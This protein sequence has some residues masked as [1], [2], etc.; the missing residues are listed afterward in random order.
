MAGAPSQEMY[1]D[2]V[3]PL[4]VERPE[5][6]DQVSELVREAAARHAS[7]FPLGGGT[8]LDYGLPPVCTGYIC[9]LTG[10]NRLVEYPAA[11]MTVTVQAGRTLA[12]LQEILQERGQWLPIDVPLPQRT[13]LGG[14]LATNLP[15]PRRY[16]YGTW[17]DYVLGMVVVNDRGELTRSGGRVVKNVAG[18]DLHKLHIGALGTLGVIVEVTLKVRPLPQHNALLCWRCS[19]RTLA[20]FLDTVHRSQTRPVTVTVINKTA[21]HWCQA[22]PLWP[23][24]DQYLVFIGFEEKT[25][26]VAWQRE[27]ICRELAQVPESE[28]VHE[29]TA[30][31]GSALWQWFADFPVLPS[32]KVSFRANVLPSQTSF[33]LQSCRHLGE[34]GVVAHAGTGTIYGHW[35]DVTESALVEQ[36]RKLRD[37]LSALNRV[38]AEAAPASGRLILLRC[39]RAWKTPQLVWGEPAAD[40][41]LQHKVKQAFDPQNRFNAGRFPAGW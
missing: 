19:E 40:Q 21:A 17:R 33:M 28:L 8:L 11:D 22:A 29:W 7:V 27:Q 13:T 15:G 35:L 41:L 39:P 30:A 16:G 37:T 25:S 1:L 26:S 34:I 14:A 20:N 23:E 32:A 24:S 10:L 9:D 4:A 36:V 18:Y 12:Q 31:A 2:G 3:G 5:H 38:S 6:P